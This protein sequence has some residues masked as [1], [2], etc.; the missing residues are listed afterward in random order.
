MALLE[1]DGM[2]MVQR[3]IVALLVVALHGTPGCVGEPPPVVPPPEPITSGTILVADSG[4]GR[5]LELDR[6]SGE[7][8]AQFDLAELLP[9]ACGKPVDTGGPQCHAFGAF[10][11]ST[12]RVDDVLVLTFDRLRVHGHM[13]YG[14]G[15]VRVWPSDPPYVKWHVHALRFLE[16]APEFEKCKEGYWGN[17][18][19]LH[20]PHDVTRLSSKYFVV[21]DTLNDRLLMLSYRSHPEKPNHTALVHWIL[22]GSSAGWGGAQHPVAVETALLE[23][24]QFLLVTFARSKEDDPEDPAG[25]MIQLWEVTSLLEPVHLW[26]YPTEGTLASPHN[27]SV[28]ERDDALY[29]VYGH[30]RGHGQGTGDEPQGSVGLAQL[31]LPAPP[32]YLGDFVADGEQLPLG[33][34]RAA[35]GIENGARLL[36]TDSG[37]ENRSELCQRHPRL[38]VADMEIPSPPGRSGAYT[39]DHD[40]Q[41]FVPIRLEPLLDDEELLS[42]PFVALYDPG[43][44]LE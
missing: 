39:P 35:T 19:F 24:R 43:A 7:V 28:V 37:C 2:P 34:I 27:A 6:L 25:G 38:L 20:A 18:C 16:D 14:G 10:R 23:D 41:V 31:N 40:H 4:H 1:A 8:T 9:E 13:G 36:V 21:A 17:E 32:L 44:P 15:L 5:Y 29:M 11:E 30:G 26:T 3:C 12:L 33:F 42:H 22:N